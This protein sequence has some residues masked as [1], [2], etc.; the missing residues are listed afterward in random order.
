M[1]NEKDIDK[2][3]NEVEHKLRKTKFGNVKIVM[4]ETSNFIDI[5][6]EERTRIFK[7]RNFNKDILDKGSSIR[8]G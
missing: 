1:A 6:T 4:S 3:L 5:V 7:D 2:V 8:K